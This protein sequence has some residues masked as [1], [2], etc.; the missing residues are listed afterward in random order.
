M[1]NVTIAEA[2]RN[3]P[4]VLEFA[5]REPVRIQSDGHDLIVVSAV[6][7]EEVQEELRKQRVQALLNAM[8]RCSEEAR[9][10]GFTDD[11]LPD[12]LRR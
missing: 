7:F 9:N 2:E 8:E 5:A 4:E 3:L 6:Q 12:I 11:M 1:R 10:N